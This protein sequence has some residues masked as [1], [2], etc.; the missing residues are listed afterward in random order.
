M[1]KTFNA[2]KYFQEHLCYTEEQ[3]KV[4][5]PQTQYAHIFS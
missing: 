4:R 3:V 5:M 1:I 2:I